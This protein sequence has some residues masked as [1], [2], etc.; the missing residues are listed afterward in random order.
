MDKDLLQY[1]AKR[2]NEEYHLF[3]CRYTPCPSPPPP[4]SYDQCGSIPLFFTLSSL[5]AEG[6][7]GLS[8][9][10]GRGRRTQIR[11]QKK[12]VGFFLYILFSQ[13]TLKRGRVYFFIHCTCKDKD[14]L[15][16]ISK[17]VTKT[18]IFLFLSLGYF[19]LEN[20]DL[21]V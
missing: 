12:T 6:R 1:N 7:A 19:H 10:T 20:Y 21:K 5:C 9:L 4:P 17:Y 15:H 14:L 13:C 16:F 11:R 8:L 2:L 18:L 3:C